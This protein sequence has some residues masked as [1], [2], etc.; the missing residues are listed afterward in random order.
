MVGEEPGSETTIDPR[1]SFLHQTVWKRIAIVAAGPISNILFAFV[2]ICAVFYIYGLQV[3]SES[4]RIGSVLEDMPAAAAGMK[5]GDLVVAL[6]GRSIATWTELSEAIRS[7][8]GREIVLRIQRG[9]ETRELALRAIQ[10]P[11]KNIFGEEK[12]AAY[13]IGIGPTIERERV[14]LAQAVLQG[15]NYTVSLMDTIV[16]GIVKLVQGRISRTDIGGPILIVQAA[17]QQAQAG[18]ENLLHFMAVISVNLGLLNLLP[19]PILD[20]G[21]LLFFFIEAVLRRPVAIRQREIAQ[22]VGLVILVV[23]MA[24]AFY[25]DIARIIRGWG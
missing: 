16:T 11:E 13:F 15:A 21:H 7:S 5:S 25:N 6:D 8:Q 22:Q 19:I 10:K 23:L 4:A 2:A 18:L 12:G 9:D 17:G 1:V 3:Q 24:F 20:G 14:G